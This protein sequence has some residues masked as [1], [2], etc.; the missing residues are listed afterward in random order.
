[1]GD[2]FPTAQHCGMVAAA[3]V[4]GYLDRRYLAAKLKS[5]TT[6]IARDVRAAGP[7]PPARRSSGDT[8]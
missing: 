2:W 1:V 7:V 4:I 8:G 6:D 3:I 5:D